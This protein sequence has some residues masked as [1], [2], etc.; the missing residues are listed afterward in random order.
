MAFNILKRAVGQSR[1]WTMYCHS[2]GPPR[3]ESGVLWFM[4]ADT[5]TAPRG[6]NVNETVIF[7]TKGATRHMKEKSHKFGSL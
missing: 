6:I 4:M 7:T 3:I 5:A 2:V 1:D